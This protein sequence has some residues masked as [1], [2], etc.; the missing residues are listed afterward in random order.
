[1]MTLDLDLYFR[2][3]QPPMVIMTYMGIVT[4]HLLMIVTFYYHNTNITVDLWK[5][6]PTL[7]WMVT[8]VIAAM[9][10]Y[11]IEG[12]NYSLPVLSS[13]SFGQSFEP[14][15]YDIA[16]ILQRLNL[17]EAYAFWY[18]WFIESNNTWITLDFLFIGFWFFIL[19]LM[20]FS[21]V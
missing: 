1:M 18:H 10:A 6:L 8:K 4:L 9:I 5:N 16:R 17:H 13:Y 7:I 15:V 21:H 12:E 20:L 11:Y 3:E 19:Q 14:I 2:L